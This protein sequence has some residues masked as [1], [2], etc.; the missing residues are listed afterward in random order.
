MF[1][2]LERAAALAAV[3]VLALAAVALAAQPK[4]GK[5]YA[6]TT[7]AHKLNGFK[8]AVTFKVSSTGGR[9][10]KFVYQDQGCFGS[11]GHLTPGVNYLAK[12]WNVHAVGA[13]KIGK[14]GKFS[15]K[16]VKSKYKVQNQTTVTT[17][18]VSGKFKN[19]KTAVG[20]ITFTQKFSLPGQPGSS[21]GPATVTFKATAH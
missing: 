9:I 16:N 15:V 11:G 19:G 8:A 7:S 5:K 20:T 21:C 10:L 2:R 3:V 4:A 17:T 12:P 1:S 14:N 13:I 6:G 18:S